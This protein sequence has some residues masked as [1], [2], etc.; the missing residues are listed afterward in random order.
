MVCDTWKHTID[1]LPSMVCTITDSIEYCTMSCDNSINF[2]SEVLNLI[3]SLY[4]IQR[5]I[6]RNMLY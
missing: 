3:S 6:A 4:Y 2:D 1:V 5:N